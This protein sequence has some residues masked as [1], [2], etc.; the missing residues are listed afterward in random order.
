[1]LEFFTG[2]RSSLNN[3][4]MLYNLLIMLNWN[5]HSIQS[6]FVGCCM[7]LHNVPTKWNEKIRSSKPC[8]GDTPEHRYYRLKNIGNDM[9]CLAAI[10]D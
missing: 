4:I 8:F 9:G 1:M 5:S 3:E 6:E 7:I 2:N 10:I